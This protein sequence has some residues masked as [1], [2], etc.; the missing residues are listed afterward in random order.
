MMDERQQLTAGRAAQAVLGILMVAIIG[1]LAYDYFA[2]D[3][4]A[5]WPMG[6][7][8]GVGLLFWVFNRSGATANPPRRLWGVGPDLE[9]DR[10]ARGERVRSYAVDASLLAAGISMLTVMGVMF[11]REQLG[12]DQLFAW[13]G[14]AG[15]MLLTVFLV[16]E[17]VG[18]W[19]VSFV[20]AFV[21]GELASATCERALAVQD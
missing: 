18:T 16:V 8:L 2:H 19:V 12:F 14:L 10:S 7:L 20:L 6:I 17:L 13:T 5:A 9:T 15:P 1:Y 11:G 3:H 4:I 21:N